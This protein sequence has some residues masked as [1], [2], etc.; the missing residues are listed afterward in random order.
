MRSFL[1]FVFLGC[2]YCG[3]LPLLAQAPT[4]AQPAT[5]APV[6][7]NPDLRFRAL[8]EHEQRGAVLKIR[9]KLLYERGEEAKRVR[10]I[11]GFTNTLQSALM[12]PDDMQ[13]LAGLVTL[14]QETNKTLEEVNS[15][16]RRQLE[17]IGLIDNA[18][19]A[20]GLPPQVANFLQEAKKQANQL[21]FNQI[22]QAKQLRGFGQTVQMAI[23]N[24]PPPKSYISQ[25]GIT[26]LLCRQGRDAFYVSEK[27]ISVAQ[28]Q[29]LTQPMA[30]T[31][32]NLADAKDI[33]SPTKTGL[34]LVE[35]LHFC[36]LMSRFE[37]NAYILLN[38]NR[39]NYYPL[40]PQ[41]RTEKQ[42]YALPDNKQ[43]QLLSLAGYSPTCALW[44][45][46]PWP[47]SDLETERAQER[48]AVSFN[49]VWDPQEH[50]AGGKTFGEL[51]F[52]RYQQ[53]GFVVV[54]PLQTGWN[55]RWQRLLNKMDA[56]LAA[57]GGDIPALPAQ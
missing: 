50:F 5:T 13:Q 10:N 39:G 3:I 23:I 30:G 1:V 52:A 11:A 34:N 33:P 14:W 44:I 26:M 19:L 42:L 40:I 49:I 4:G 2:I 54:T 29:A 57:R 9:D 17:L 55:L 45:N 22:N 12:T 24:V 37:Q 16:N 53:L 51:P 15:A 36:H 21:G 35:A 8:E 32:V 41:A 47:P 31:N 20:G 18:M 27:P 46:S 48:F 56:D 25:S 28:Y 43:L 7:A 6:D 38:I